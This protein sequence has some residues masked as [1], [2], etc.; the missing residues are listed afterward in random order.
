MRKKAKVIFL[1]IFALCLCTCFFHAS[2]A[3]TYTIS[4]YQIHADIDKSA[5]MKVEENITF[6][7]NPSMTFEKDILQDY[8]YDADQDG[9][10]EIYAYEISSI[11]IEGADYTTS[12][13]NGAHR[14]RLT[15]E[16]PDANII[17]HYQV[18]FRRYD[19]EDANIFLYQLISPN[20]SG[21]I[22]S[23]NA[24][25]TPQIK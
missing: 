21:T 18:R 16:K 15:L 7:D 4:S 3:Q 19:A 8:S 17:I 9:T 23:F 14:L 10:P 6:K 1:W 24:S 2:A 12:Y 13:E 11:R 25:I 20:H 5:V 22:E